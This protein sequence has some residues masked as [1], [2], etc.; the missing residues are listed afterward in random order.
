MTVAPCHPVG[1]HVLKTPGVLRQDSPGQRQGRQ[2]T[3]VRRSVGLEG[4][5][6]P[7]PPRERV[8][9]SRVRTSATPAVPQSR[10][11]GVPSYPKRDGGAHRGPSHGERLSARAQDPLQRTLLGRS[12]PPGMEDRR[13]LARIPVWLQIRPARRGC[14]VVLVAVN[15]LGMGL[16]VVL[17]QHGA[18]FPG[19]I[20]DGAS[21]DRAA[22]QRELGHGDRV[23]GEGGVAHRLPSCQAAVGSRIDGSL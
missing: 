12:E 8:A 17:G 1:G 14:R 19:S 3:G 11:A 2:T 22:H 18:G 7:F 13:V 9:L 20:G 5:R 6:E 10:R 16:L 21:A 15:Q 23:A 4:D